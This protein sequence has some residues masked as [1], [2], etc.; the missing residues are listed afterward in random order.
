MPLSD[1]LTRFAARALGR[2]PAAKIEVGPPAPVDVARPYHVAW[3][4]HNLPTSFRKGE[5][6]QVYLRV[7][8]RGSRHWHAN[9]LGGQW[10]ELAVYIGAGSPPHGE[11][12]PRR[13]SR[14]GRPFYHPGGVSA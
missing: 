6:Y 1:V 7:E 12:S 8:N 2:T 5:H 4:R 3:L 13:G 11:D 10:V 9:H 14:G